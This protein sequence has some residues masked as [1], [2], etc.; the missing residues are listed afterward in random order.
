MK[1]SPYLFI[2]FFSFGLIQAQNQ[3]HFEFEEASGS[4][5]AFDSASNS[6]F[7]IFNHYSSPER[8]SGPSN[9]A[10]RLDG[11]ST[12]V[13]LGT[14]CLDSAS[15]ELSISLWYATEAFSQDGGALVSK[16]DQ[17][18]GIELRVNPFGRV[19]FQFYTTNFSH[20]LSS[21]HSI[22]HY[23]WVKLGV[24]FS[25]SKGFARLFL[26]GTVV[27]SVVV[28]NS[29]SL[30]IPS[31]QT[32]RIGRSSQNQTAYGFSTVTANGAIDQVIIENTSYNAPYYSVQ[33]NGSFNAVQ[34]LYIDPSIRHFGDHLRP[35]YHAMP[36]TSWTNESYGLTYF[37]GAYHLFFQKN[38]NAPA[39]FFMHWGHLVSS[40]L[41]HWREETMPLA[42]EPG[43]DDW[44][45]WSGTTVFD[46][47]GM[48]VIFYTGVDGQKAGI[49]RALA[50]DSALLNWE[51]D[52]ANPLI[53]NP[54]PSYN[55]MD[56]RDPYVFEYNN[57]YYMIVGSGLA[58]N[59][60][61]ILFSYK[62]TDL[63]NWN[64]MLPIFQHNKVSELGTFWEMPYLFE[65]KKDTFLLGL[66]PLGMP[67]VRA[68]YS[69]GTFSN[70]KFV[71]FLDEADFKDIE[72]IEN[73][74]LA[75]AF[76]KDEWGEYV[77]CGIVPDQR[78][79]SDQVAAGWRHMFSLPRRV[80]VCDDGKTLGQY[81][82]PN[83]CSLRDTNNSVNVSNVAVSA[84]N[85]WKLPNWSSQQ[86]EFEGSI[87][88]AN[89][90][91]ISLEFLNDTVTNRAVKVE[92][93]FL[94][95]KV[96]LNRQSSSPYLCT[97]DRQVADYIFSQ[98]DS[99]F[100]R[101]FVD[102]SI[103]EVFI[104]NLAVMSA[105]VYPHPNQ[106]QFSIKC[107]TGSATINGTFFPLFGMLETLNNYSN[108]C[109]PSE[110]PIGMHGYLAGPENE[111]S[112]SSSIIPNPSSNYI[113]LDKH[114]FGKKYSIYNSE[115]RTIKIGKIEGPISIFELENGTY[116]LKIEKELIVFKFIKI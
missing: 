34:N 36:N 84:N 81:A 76:G 7:A 72:L 79:V 95:D 14:N 21:P 65:I 42:P 52:S 89:G 10:L 22:A 108:Y 25:R 37:N 92:F 71:P 66:G 113:H 41:V 96:Y 103:I 74:L 15:E 30:L 20:T 48:P 102:H 5:T 80:Y 77:Y 64:F 97:Q 99:V 83:L 104:D 2:F 105:R 73:H 19:E 6:T 4:V 8:I 88:K 29:D 111:S 24:D 100:F 63:K 114:Y 53:P 62:S 33:F 85:N 90:S 46:S 94:N 16:I 12:F 55:H 58:G 45:T 26:N 3:F 54:P 23:E 86:F 109:P 13:D 115:G 49:G 39:L 35:Q 60:G 9:Q 57:I 1:Y 40:D 69:L 61:G 82:H 68:L 47:S 50:S 106:T 67:K 44:G 70:N 56:F 93:D 51:K 98:K 31:T 11:F 110:I 112:F 87:S 17:N 78:S 38:P 32:L 59:G 18:S 75:P 107:L 116:Q 91:F 101:V 27:D 43:W 28:S